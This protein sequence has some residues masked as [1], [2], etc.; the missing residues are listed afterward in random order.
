MTAMRQGFE[1]LIS[2]FSNL[3]FQ[4][5]FSPNESNGK[6]GWLG[7]TWDS[8]KSWFYGLPEPAKA[9]LPED[10]VLGANILNNPDQLPPLLQPRAPYVPL[11]GV[12]TQ[13]SSYD[14]SPIQIE[15]RLLLDGRELAFVIAEIIQRNRAVNGQGFGGDPFGF[16]TGLA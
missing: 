5:L 16:N 10:T 15:N 6:S 4:S 8:L 2:F 1:N 12:P 9:A 11:S 7:E 13:L 3:T 14:G